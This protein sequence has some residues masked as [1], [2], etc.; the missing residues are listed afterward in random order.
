MA[1]AARLFFPE[2]GTIVHVGALGGRAVKLD[3]NGGVEDFV[4][5]EECAAGAGVFIEI[6]ANAL[7]VEPW[8]MGPMALRS[9]RKIPMNA[10]CVI[11]AE[12]EVPGLIQSGVS[13]DDIS[14]A[15]HDAMAGRVTSMMLRIGLNGDVVM[16]GRL[17]R[18]PAFIE[19]V[20]KGL[21]IEK[22]WVPDSPEYGIAIG[23]ALAAAQEGLGLPGAK[24]GRKGA[25]AGQGIVRWTGKLRVG[26]KNQKS[27]L[28]SEACW[29]DP[30][31]DWKAADYLTAGIDVGSVSSQACIVAD[32]RILAYANIRA[33]PGGVGSAEKALGS[34]L[35]SADMPGE[36]INYCVGTGYGRVNVPFA[37]RVITEIA[38]LARGANFIYGPRVRTVLDVGGQDIKAIRCDGKGKV[39]GF[40]MNDKCA[41]GTGRGMEVFAEMLGVALNDVGECSFQVEK[42]PQAVSNTCVVYAC[43]EAS[44]MLRQGLGVEDVLAAYCRAMAGHVHSLLER[45]GVI[46]GFAVTGGIA[47]NRGVMDRLI[48]LVGIDGLK[49]KW[50]PQIAGAVGAA[51]FGHRLCLRGKGRRREM[52]AF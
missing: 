6:M 52:R 39:V 29:R 4:V 27:G 50:D 11:F 1:R 38:C 2:S 49:T 12:S 18:S 3:R 26:K 19:A 7:E 36:R 23:A 43:L 33:C 25:F 37:D 9:G 22:I 13:R 15:V 40:L 31:L 48:P 42:E 46:P 41:V 34:A 24:F 35:E 44:E 45:A 20:R 10:Q 21:K 14:G 28:Q 17:A 30:D 5:E 16:I 32:G 51:L 47:K 8:Q